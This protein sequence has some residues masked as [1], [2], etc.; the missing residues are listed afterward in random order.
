LKQEARTRNKVQ[1]NDGKTTGAAREEEEQE[2]QDAPV[3]D[4]PKQED[5]HQE[6]LQQDPLRLQEAEYQ[7]CLRAGAGNFTVAA[8]VEALNELSHGLCILLKT[9]TSLGVGFVDFRE[10][11][12]QCVRAVVEMLERRPELRDPTVVPDAAQ[13]AP[14][15]QTS[16]TEKILAAKARVAALRLSEREVSVLTHLR[17]RAL[18]CM[19]HL[20]SSPCAAAQILLGACGV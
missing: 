13:D 18:D 15:L 12:L 20:V 4:S 5:V 1:V 10:R 9:L 17:T 8:S 2:E 16:W 14:P 7:Q 11:A 19:K 3:I 6:G